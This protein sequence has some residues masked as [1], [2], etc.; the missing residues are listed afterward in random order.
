MKH[1]DPW[2]L[3]V[4]CAVLALAT[5]DLLAQDAPAA[6]LPPTPVAHVA[7]PSVKPPP[8][9]RLPNGDIRLGKIVLHRKERTLAFPATVALRQGALEVL[10]ATTSGRTYESLLST[11][12]RPLYLQTLLYLLGLENGP[13]DPGPDARRTGDQVD[14]DVEW[15]T[16]KGEKRRQPIED[17]V[18]DNRTEKPMRRLGWVFVG[19]SFQNGNCLADLEGNVVLLYTSGATILETADRRSS[20]DTLFSAD[21]TRVRLDPGATVTV[22]VKPRSVSHPTGGLRTPNPEP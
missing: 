7:P 2:Q 18:R 13:R 4:S 20:D 16:A 21:L 12:I 3:I 11:T 14:I 8:I 19:S 22:I 15:V 6:G 1:R 10:I 5:A 17:W 9:E